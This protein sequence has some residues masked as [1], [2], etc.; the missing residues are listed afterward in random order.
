[1]YALHTYMYIAQ[2]SKHMFSSYIAILYNY[3]ESFAEE[4]ICK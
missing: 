2:G 3:W 1:M 4:N